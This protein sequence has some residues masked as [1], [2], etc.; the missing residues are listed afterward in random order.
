MKFPEFDTDSLTYLRRASRIIHARNPQCQV[1]DVVKG[2]LEAVYE[3]GMYQ[4]G[5]GKA[6]R[7]RIIMAEEDELVNKILEGYTPIKPSTRP[8]HPTNRQYLS[9]V[10]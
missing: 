9:K 8:S 10:S 5:R 7:E 2:I 3:R 4:D 6:L 1:E